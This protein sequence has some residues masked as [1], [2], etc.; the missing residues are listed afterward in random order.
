MEETR[1]KE[2]SKEY[3]IN[4]NSQELPSLIIRKVEGLGDFRTKEIHLESKGYTFR[5]AKAGLNKLIKEYKK[6]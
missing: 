6:L 1:K 4:H 2:E 3:N 5:E